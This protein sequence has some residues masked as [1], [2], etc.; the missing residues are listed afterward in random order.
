MSLKGALGRGAVLVGAW[1]LVQIP[2][3]DVRLTEPGSNMPP[4]T[5]FKKVRQFSSGGE[6]EAFRDVAV[7]DS[8]MMGSEAMLDQSSQLRCVREE[9]LAQPTAAPPTPG[10]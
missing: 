1:W 7:Q 5:Q 6:C 4:I 9:Q 8:A 2:A 3:K 10:A